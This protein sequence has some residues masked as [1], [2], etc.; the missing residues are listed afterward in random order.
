MIDN[1]ISN[2]FTYS[3]VSEYSILTYFDL[4]IQW[5]EDKIH[6]YLNEIL[7]NY[8][9]LKQTF[10]KNHSC[11]RDIH[12]F[13]INQCLTIKYV[14]Q[15]RFHKYIRSILNT[16]FTEY[17][18]MMCVLIDKHNDKSRVYF[19]IHHAYADGYKLIEMLISPFLQTKYK[20][21][22]F[23]R[24]TNCFHSIYYW[25]IGTLTL[26]VTT[27]V[28]CLK[29][30][31]KQSKTTDEVI[32]EDTYTDYITCKLDFNVIKTFVKQHNMTVNDFLYA[33]MIKTDTLYTNQTNTIAVLSPVNLSQLNKLN[34]MGMILSLFDNSLDNKT[35]LKNVHNLFNHYKYSLF[36]HFFNL[37]TKIISYL[38]LH[39][40]FIF[41][42]K[43]MVRNNFYI[44]SN[45]IGPPLD[46][47]NLHVTDIHF[48]TTT[49]NTS[50]I[51]YNIISC[52]DKINLICTF[53]KNKIKDKSRFKKCIYKAYHNLLSTYKLI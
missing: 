6:A 35:L 7:I 33:L 3:D 41:I 25:I 27:F 53:Q 22:L 19:R 30:M 14:R 39:T 12:P 24:K 5:S 47:F 2:F 43:R 48:L 46:N 45:M 8:P 40:I 37:S 9:I 36:I 4:D 20:Q 28:A 17:K 44:Y 15:N 16:P 49:T 32:A 52:K 26:I 42:Y 50:C 23:H 51:S 31:M 34:N 10:V 29:C 21:P 1:V 18:F 38:N 13:D 11:L